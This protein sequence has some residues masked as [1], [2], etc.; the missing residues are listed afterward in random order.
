MFVIT[1]SIVITLIPYLTPFCIEYLATRPDKGMYQKVGW[2]PDWII[3]LL[4]LAEQE[5]LHPLASLV[6]IL[7]AKR[8]ESVLVYTGGWL[9]KRDWSSLPRFIFKPDLEMWDTLLSSLSMAPCFSSLLFLVIHLEA[10]GMGFGDTIGNSILKYAVI[11]FY[12]GIPVWWLKWHLS[13]HYTQVGG[14]IGEHLG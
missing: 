3:S 8:L 5:F 13:R 1:A 11:S 10:K 4:I 14:W 2:F 12:I 9:G 7:V 6:A